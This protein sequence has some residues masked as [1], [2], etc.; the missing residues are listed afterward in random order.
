MVGASQLSLDSRVQRREDVP[1][2]TLDG[3]VMLL[4]LASGDFFELDDVGSRIWEGLDGRRTVA[5]QAAV[6]A[7][8]YDV[9][10]ERARSD[11]IAFLADLDAK[12]LIRI[13]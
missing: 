10:L 8:A 6:V 9:S 13:G 3:V 1:W 7:D 5:D 4:D 12:G 2:K 11:V